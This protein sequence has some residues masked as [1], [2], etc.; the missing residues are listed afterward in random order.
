MRRIPALLGHEA[1]AALGVGELEAT[2]GCS[3]L[4]KT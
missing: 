1:L 2:P 3:G 4:K